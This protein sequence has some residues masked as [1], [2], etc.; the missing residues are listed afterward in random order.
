ML[1]DGHLLAVI[2][3]AKDGAYPT[4]IEDV[5]GWT[6][7]PP[8]PAGDDGYSAT[9]A[10]VGPDGMLYLLER[11]TTILMSFVTRIRRFPVGALGIGAGEVVFQ[12]EAGDLP[13]MEGISLW[14]AP[15]GATIGD[16]DL[17]QWFQ[18]DGY[19]DRG[20]P[21]YGVSAAPRARACC[22]T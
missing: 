4:F 6:E 9:S 22:L 16:S 21:A 2:E 13:N 11:R 15:D 14:R 3:R 17:G 18:R 12:S 10:D 1:P 7:G 8:I 20:V 5:T 19:G